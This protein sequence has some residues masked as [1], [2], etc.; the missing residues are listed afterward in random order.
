MPQS[1]HPL[2]H[3][4]QPRQLLE[5]SQQILAALEGWLTRP[6]EGESGLH[7]SHRDQS[8]VEYLLTDLAGQLDQLE[9]ALG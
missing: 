4:P 5:K 1:A 7:L 2:P 3:I 8:G 6:V 9:R